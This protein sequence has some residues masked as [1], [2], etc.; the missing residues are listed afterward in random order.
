[1]T[2]I[3]SV[4]RAA[5]PPPRKNGNEPD[6]LPEHRQKTVEAGLAAYQKIL[7]EREELESRLREASMT[8]EGLTVQLNALKGVVNMMESTYL[9]AKL[10]AEN[11]VNTYQSQR[12]EAVTRTAQLETTLSNIVVV[13]RNAVIE[14]ESPS[15]AG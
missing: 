15:S 13:I 5:A 10:E 2:T 12:D 9:T 3:T 7:A 1:M 8:I 6:Q 14:P 11:R 4:H